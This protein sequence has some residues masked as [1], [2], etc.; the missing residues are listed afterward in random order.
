[1]KK[2]VLWLILLAAFLGVKQLSAAANEN[3][4]FVELAKKIAPVHYRLHL[5]GKMGP[6]EEFFAIYEPTA[7]EPRIKE[8][9]QK[10]VAH[11]AWFDRQMKRGWKSDPSDPEP[12]RS[13]ASFFELFKAKVGAQQNM[14]DAPKVEMDVY[15]GSG[16]VVRFL[17]KVMYQPGGLGPWK[18]SFEL[19][20]MVI[21]K[22]KGAQVFRDKW[23][24]L[25]EEE[26]DELY[27]NEFK[28]LSDEDKARALY[29]ALDLEIFFDAVKS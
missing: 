4:G 9:K 8:D 26:I 11:S 29:D 27:N 25:S 12:E 18:G 20:F 6:P 17:D 1:M 2:K 13:K 23:T 28:A 16:T 14:K 15:R 7:D 5:A 22:A 3:E 21:D 24:Y 19:P 10:G